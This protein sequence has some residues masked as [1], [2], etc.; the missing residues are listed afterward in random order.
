MSPPNMLRRKRGRPKVV[1]DEAQ[2]ALVVEGAR[3]LFLEKGYGRTTTDD[4][5]ER[6]RISKQTLY[7]LFPS[8]QDLFAAVVDVHRQSMLA[9]PGNYEGMT[10]DEALQKIFKLDIDARA[11]WER[12][13]LLRMV[14]LEAP[15]FPELLNIMRHQGAQRSHAELASWLSEM[16]ERGAIETDDTSSIARILM[17]MIFAPPILETD[18]IGR[19]SP[20]GHQAHIRRCIQVFLRGVTPR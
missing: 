14:M 7:R 17:D 8:K 4:V 19:G 18:G 15:Q 3:T 5:A 11:D 1:T 10:L 9:L 2:R 6:C 16:R 12:M 20:D 13:A